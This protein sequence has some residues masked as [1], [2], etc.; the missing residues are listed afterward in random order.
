MSGL[1]RLCFG[2]E[3]DQ[4]TWSD[5]S[6]CRYV[7]RSLEGGTAGAA[8]LR[9]ECGVY[10]VRWLAC[11]VGV[12]TDGPGDPSHGIGPLTLTTAAGTTVTRT[13]V[14][15]RGAGGRWTMHFRN[16]ELTPAVGA[17]WQIASLP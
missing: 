17:A 12:G 9:G 7:G 8:I 15:K 13:G 4:E 11:G 5:S 1:G 14:L 2:F 3:V 10:S 16:Y 6:F